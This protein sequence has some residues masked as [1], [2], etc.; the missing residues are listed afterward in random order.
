MT[1]E[2]ILRLADT[3]VKCGMCIPHC[4]TYRKTLQESNSPRGR[5][6][7]V[8]G[9]LVGTI[10]DNQRVAECLDRCLECHACESV[11]PAGT[12]VTSII[13]AVRAVRMERR[14]DLSSWL[15]KQLLVLAVH[16][17]WWMPWLGIYQ[18]SRLRSW[19]QRS[20]VLTWLGLSHAE[21][22]LPQRPFT[23]AMITP[24]VT[25]AAVAE[26]SV[27]IGLFPGCLGRFVDAAALEAT[28]KILSCL[29]HKV[30]IPSQTCCCGALYRH[31][32]FANL[33]S[34][35]LERTSKLFSQYERILTVASACLET[36][37]HAPDM[38]PRLDDATRYIAALPWPA[39]LRIDSSPQTIWVH[40]PCSQGHPIGDSHAAMRLLTRI[41]G[42][43]VLTL[44]ENTV[45]CGAAGTY[46]LRQPSLSEAL[47]ADKLHLIAAAGAT[48]VVTTNT[49]CAL[50][51]A[52]G[53]RSQGVRVCHPLEI[54]AERILKS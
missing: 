38:Q 49:G 34:L 44:P 8:Q 35:E 2:Q 6:A 27:S 39:T 47:L 41:P 46:M 1:P 50:R 33:G 25:V 13:D 4:P 51:L 26:H 31:D 52:A 32:G 21:Q 48:T 14:T 24:L 29:G 15:R 23:A 40:V 42:V 12:Q 20:G 7:I 43:K 16:P 36:L 17:Q 30:T 5:I 28:A 53:L 37:R 11:C 9:L 54:L 18:Q 45:C 22:L 3:C 10:P 19:L